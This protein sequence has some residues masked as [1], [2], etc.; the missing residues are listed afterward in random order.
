MKIFLIQERSIYP[1]RFSPVY[2]HQE[3]YYDDS[4]HQLKIAAAGL[5]FFLDTTALYGKIKVVLFQMHHLRYTQP[6]GNAPADFCGEHQ[7]GLIDTA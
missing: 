4:A 1:H 6:V 2:L 3:G 5:C 7:P